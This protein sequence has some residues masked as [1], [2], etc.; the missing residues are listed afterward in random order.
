MGA[1]LIKPLLRSASEKIADVK[2]FKKDLPD[3]EAVRVCSKTS[4]ILTPPSIFSKFQG[5][6][7]SSA[8][9]AYA[10]ESMAF[11]T[12]GIMDDYDRPDLVTEST[13]VRVCFQ[14]IG[15]CN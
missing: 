15:T 3:M 1:S 7:A 5:C 9:N 11:L 13:A 2:R 14:A 6:L 8:I 4:L 10:M 12:A